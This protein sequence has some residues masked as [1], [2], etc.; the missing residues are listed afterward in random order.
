MGNLKKQ[1]RQAERPFETGKSPRGASLFNIP[2]SLFKWRTAIVDFEGPFHWA[3][4]DRTYLLRHI[5]ARLHNFETMTWG[6]IEGRDNHFVEAKDLC[7][8]ARAR[9]GA[10]D[11]DHVESLFSIHITGRQ[12]LWGHREGAV[13]QV[14]WWD[15][16]H[17]VCP[18]ALK[19]T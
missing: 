11:M 5:V 10:L 14:L 4:I 16:E 19:H 1:P 18:S 17:A 2:A 9:L 15:P 12:R 8:D 3:D 7:K 6:E 13:L